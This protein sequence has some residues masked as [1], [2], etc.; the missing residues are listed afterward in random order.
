MI[1]IGGYN[2]SGIQIWDAKTGKLLST[3]KVN[4]TVWS[5][6][7][8]SD[9]KKL[10]AGLSSGSIRIFDTATWQQI[11]DLEGHTSVVY[12]ITLF[13]NDRLLASTSWDRTARLWNLDTNLQVG[14]PLQHDTDVECAAFSADGKLLSTACDENAYVWDIRDILKTAGL[15]DLLSVPDAQKSELKKKVCI[16][17]WLFE[18]PKTRLCPTCTRHCQVLMLRD[19]HPSVQLPVKCQQAFSITCKAVILHPL[20]AVSSLIPLYVVVAAAVLLHYPGDRVHSRSSLTFLN[21]SAIHNTL[22]N[23][24]NLNSAQGP[25]PP[26]VAVLLLSK[27]LH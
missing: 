15:E 8:T 23:Q 6:T 26:L 12:S 2:E 24:S 13:S 16:I 7:W 10:I 27:F 21:S 5:L 9:K 22:M 1:A 3:I 11:A 17:S 4:T 14:S 19:V 25:V 20:L 18:N